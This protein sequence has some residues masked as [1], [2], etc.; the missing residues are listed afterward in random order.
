VVKT[1]WVVLV[2][3]KSILKNRDKNIETHFCVYKNM[4]V[5]HL[6]IVAFLN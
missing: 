1:I 3:H 5:A 4:D 2:L 6:G